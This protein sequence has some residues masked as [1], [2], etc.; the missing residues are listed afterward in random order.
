E[1]H[2]KNYGQALD[3]LKKAEEFIPSNQHFSASIPVYKS[4]SRYYKEMD[5]PREAMYYDSLHFQGVKTRANF[6]ERLS[7]R[8]VQ[9]RL[10]EQ[11]SARER[12][13]ILYGASGSLAVLVL[14]LFVRLRMVRREERRR[15]EAFVQKTQAASPPLSVNGNRSLVKNGVDNPGLLIMPL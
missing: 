3:Y 10:T 1:L 15:Y 9:N 2:N 14:L 5:S 11:S 8:L 6:T 7:D 4:L 12:S 13:V